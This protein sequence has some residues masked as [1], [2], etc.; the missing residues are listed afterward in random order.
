MLRIICAVADVAVASFVD[1]AV[2]FTQAI[3]DIIFVH[4]ISKSKSLFLTDLSIW[5]NALSCFNFFGQCL[6]VKRSSI[7][8]FSDHLCV[9]SYLYNTNAS[10]GFK[11]ILPS[12]TVLS[13][14]V[15]RHSAPLNSSGI[16]IS[17]FLSLKLQTVRSFS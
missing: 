15:I 17:A 10:Y 7:S 16:S 3:D 12:N 6:R 14:F 9:T 1:S 4:D 2:G 5:K 11:T 13:R 8:V